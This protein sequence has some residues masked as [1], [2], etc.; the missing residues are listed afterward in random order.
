[1]PARLSHRGAFLETL[2]KA[3]RL[4]YVTLSET[5]SNPRLMSILNILI[6]KNLADCGLQ[7]EAEYVCV[8]LV[9]NN[10]DLTRLNIWHDSIRQESRCCDVKTAYFSAK[11]SFAVFMI[12]QE[13]VRIATDFS[14]FLDQQT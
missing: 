6:K 10:I 2:T 7:K 3:E 14:R 9:Q 13:L 5:S 12:V 8:F 11:S 1:M 4:N